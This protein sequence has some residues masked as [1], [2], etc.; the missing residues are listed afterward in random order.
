MASYLI[1]SFEG[2]ISPFNTKGPKGSGK[3]V[4]NADIRKSMNSLTCQQ[5]LIDE[6]IDT[7][8]FNSTIRFIVPASDGNAYG[9]SSN[10][11]IYKR[12]GSTKEW[13]LVYTDANESTTGIVGAAE[14]YEGTQAFLYWAT[15]T[16]LNRKPLPGTS[17]WSDINTGGTGSWPK[18]NLTSS[19]WHTMLQAIGT[20]FI[21][22][23][24]TIASVSYTDSSYSP[25]RLQL[26]PGNISRAL[27]E[28][29]RS[30][31]IGCDR[32][33]LQQAAATFSWDGLADSWVDKMI[34]PLRPINAL[35][36]TDVPLL[37]AGTGGGVY[38][39]DMQNRQPI[40]NFPGGGYCNPAG[41][42]TD[43]GL[44]LFG[45]YGATSGYNGVYSYGRKRAGDKWV[46]NL[47]YA[48]EATEI[49]S[50]CKVGTDLLIG[51]RNGSTYGVKRVDTTAKATAVFESLEFRSPANAKTNNRT[52]KWS[53][54]VVKTSPLPAGTSISL[55]RKLNKNSTFDKT[56][57][58]EGGATS[59]SETG[60]TEAVFYAGDMARVFEVQPTLVPSGNYS[61]EILEMEIFFD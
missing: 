36:D 44:A 26:I 47:E 25:D 16:R 58:L 24:N 2:G 42:C 54:I 31:I 39:A 38:Y 51:Y 35:L 23:S 46:L 20:L 17:N 1:D 3:M 18:T 15:D 53:K 49:G 22:N 43:E 7:G 52:V 12:N 14:W 61:P 4:K 56:C 30:I 59:F 57:N 5:A 19:T 6:T 34:L 40:F 29:G 11:K 37:Q 32:K 13:S 8:T 9:F 27:L 33:D 21:S 10:G 50:V 28:R 55:K 48:L 41:V 45:V 60:K